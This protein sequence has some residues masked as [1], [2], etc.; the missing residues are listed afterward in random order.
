MS[1]DHT[2]N[3]RTERL[4]PTE[5]TIDYENWDAA[6]LESLEVTDGIV[7][8]SNLFPDSAIAQYKFEDDG[9]LTTATDAWNGHHA[10]LHNSPSYTTDAQEGSY[11][12]SLDG[13]NQYGEL[14]ISIGDNGPPLSIRAWVQLDTIPDDFRSC[15]ATD[16]STN[17]YSLGVTSQ[18]E[19]DW[20]WRDGVQIRTG[21]F[22]TDQWY[23]IV[24]TIGDGSAELY[25]GETKVGSETYSTLT[26]PVDNTRI[27][28]SPGYN[29]DWPGL[30]DGLK[31]YSK[32]LSATEVSNLYN[33]GSI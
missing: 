24:G 17:G 18:E 33:T 5:R 3:L 32:K 31:F 2:G 7:K 20:S 14:P 26:N 23:H 6:T 30:I 27:G 19:W 29:N 21:S 25:V 16:D 12:L 10:T 4:S 22:S 11:A 13:S 1:Y 9:D 8:L 28:D 15:V